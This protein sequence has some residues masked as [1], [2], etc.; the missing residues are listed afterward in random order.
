MCGT[1]EFH[2]LSHMTWS[3]WLR[4][5]VSNVK[6]EL[7]NVSEVKWPKGLNMRQEACVYVYRVGLKRL[8]IP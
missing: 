1:V 5:F 7:R 8:T 6:A 3:C 2:F 4:A